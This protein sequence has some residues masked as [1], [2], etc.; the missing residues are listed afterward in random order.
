VKVLLETTDDGLRLIASDGT[1]ELDITDAFRMD[2]LA[3][4]WNAGV[5]KCSGV[6]TVETRRKEVQ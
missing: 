2:T 3:C 4:A 6:L 1:T 5:I